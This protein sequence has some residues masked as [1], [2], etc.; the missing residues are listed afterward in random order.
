M[1]CFF[2]KNLQL[3]KSVAPN[4]SC[5]GIQLAHAGRKASTQRPWE[6]EVLLQKQ[7]TWKTISS[8]P[9]PFQET[10]HVPQEMKLSDIERVKKQ[11]I[12]ASLKAV[13]IGFDLIEIHGTHGYL[14][15][16]FLSPISNKRKDKYGGSLENRMR[17]PLEVFLQLKTSS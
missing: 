3:A 15:H 4:K 16:Q 12:S 13:E 17:F 5:F 1:H 10:W 2:K 6:E 11:F 7:K 8:S 9:I 14:L